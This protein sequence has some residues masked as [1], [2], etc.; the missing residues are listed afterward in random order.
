MESGHLKPTIRG[1]FIPVLT[2]KA[3]QSSG[4]THQPGRAR[5]LMPAILLKCTVNTGMKT[6]VLGTFTT[7]PDIPCTF[8][9]AS[10]AS[11]PS[12]LLS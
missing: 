8:W 9:S 5:D 1:H 4:D 12:A 3:D 10:S 6:V 2:Q 7:V 11:Q